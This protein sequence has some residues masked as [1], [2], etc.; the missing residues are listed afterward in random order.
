MRPYAPLTCAFGTRLDPD[1]LL[2]GL[3]AQGI[4]AARLIVDDDGLTV[5]CAEADLRRDDVARG[6]TWLRAK[7]SP[8]VPVRVARRREGGSPRYVDARRRPREVVALAEVTDPDAG[9]G[10][11]VEDELARKELRRDTLAALLRR[12]EAL[13]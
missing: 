3:D 9:F 7:F 8:L 5:E 6:V 12:I 1:E 10:A 11:A 13:R 4:E 2:A